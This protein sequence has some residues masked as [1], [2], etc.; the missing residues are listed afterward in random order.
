MRLI[1]HMKHLFA[2]LFV[3]LS[4]SACTLGTETATQGASGGGS[5]TLR[6]AQATSEAGDNET[7]A[8]LFEK[9]LVV[10]PVSVPALLGA[11]NSYARMGQ[12][13]RAEAVLLRGHELAP[14]NAEVLTTL[15]RVYLAMQQSERAVDTYDKALRVDRTNVAALTG[16]GVALDTLSRHKQAQG[17]YEDGLQLYPTNF[18]LRSN[19][20]LS[21]AISGDIVRGTAILQELVKDP[22]A[23]PYVR[24]NLALVYGLDGRENDARATLK[25]DLTP[26]EIEENLATYRALRRMRLEG[27]Q[28]GSLVFV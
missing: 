26:Q 10:D 20:A 19:Y 1:T 5:E 23:A 2:S 22:A 18:I 9:V 7:A 6:L 16:K 11:G 15:A 3:A 21:L 13:S 14:G 4:L 28:I 8:R 27:K 17:V 24:G 12:N 25:L